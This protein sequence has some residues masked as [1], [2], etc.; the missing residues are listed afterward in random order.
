MQAITARIGIEPGTVRVAFSRL[1]KDGWIERRRSGRGSLYS[2]SARGRAPFEAASRRIYAAP[3]AARDE[4]PRLLALGP[5]AGR[6]GPG[7]AGRDAA[8]DAE[9]LA[10]LVAADAAALELR[11]RAWLLVDGGPA[12]RAALEATGC[13]VTPATLNG[14]PDWLVERLGL[15]RSARELTVLGAR[16]ARFDDAVH[17]ETAL[18]PLDALLARLLLVHAW[19]RA[20]L[21]VPALPPMLQPPGW[22]LAATRERVGALY[23]RLLPPS[24]RWLDAHGRGSHGPLPPD[25]P[26]VTE[27]FGHPATAD[28]IA[29]QNYN[30]LAVDVT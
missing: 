11:E 8:R 30:L 17:A 14:P 7:D 18:A 16:L 19:R 1:A 22:P 2:L 12:Q 27:R 21:H 24:T 9:R 23:R 13:L 15:D 25:D 29:L 26:S 3:G 10:G 6:G 4:R 20:L 28:A 5:P